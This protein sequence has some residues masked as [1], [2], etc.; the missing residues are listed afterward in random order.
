MA[1]LNLHRNSKLTQQRFFMRL[2][3]AVIL[4]LI[5]VTGTLWPV[6]HLHLETQQQNTRSEIRAILKVSENTLWRDINETL[7][8]ALAIAEMPTI[9]ALMTK[10]GEA[11]LDSPAPAELTGFLSTLIQHYPRYTKLM[12]IDNQ[13]VEVLRIPGGHPP[14]LA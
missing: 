6:L 3:L 4:P 10:D 14:T 8:Y 7:S 2:L 5:L 9:K 11:G 1:H 13:G 12:L